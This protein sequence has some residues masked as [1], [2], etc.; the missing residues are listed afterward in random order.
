MGENRLKDEPRIASD[1]KGSGK[2][3]FNFVDDKMTM[4]KMFE[5]GLPVKYIPY[6]LYITVLGIV[7][8]ANTHY[9]DRLNSSILKLQKEVEDARSAYT[10][11][12]SDY[13]YESKQSEVAKK[14]KS[15]GLIEDKN[16]PR[17]IVIKTKSE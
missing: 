10:T 12:K 3:L 13:S 9:S 15:I 6:I 11:L 7:Y 8:I 5:S 14:V 4:G 2:S 1:K 17:K 16:P